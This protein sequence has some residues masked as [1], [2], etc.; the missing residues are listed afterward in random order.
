MFS[1]SKCIR[2]WHGI[3]MRQGFPAIFSIQMNGFVG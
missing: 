1:L 2:E 3:R